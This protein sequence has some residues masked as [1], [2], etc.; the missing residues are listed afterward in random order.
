MKVDLTE[1]EPC[2]KRISIEIPEEKISEEKN[3]AYR[4]LAKSANVPGFRKGRVPRSVLEKMYEERIHSDIAQRLVQSAYQDALSSNNIKPMSDPKV[5]ELKI[6]AGSPITFSATLEVFPE[7]AIEG[8][9]KINL[10][11]KYNKASEEEITSIIDQYRERAARFEPVEERA[12]AE[13]DFAMID[14]RGTHDGEEMEHF[15]GENRQV[16]VSEKEMLSG[17]FEGVNGMKKGEERDFDANL[18][19]DFPD[20]KLKGQKVSF[21]VKLN[22][23]KKKTLPEI[24]DEFAQE[25]SEHDTIEEFKSEIGKM[26]EERSRSMAE[27]DLRTGLIDLI[28]ENNDIELPASQIEKQTEDIFGRKVTEAA[29]QGETKERSEEEDEA[30]KESCRQEAIRSLKEQVILSTF[31]IKEGLDVTPEEVEQEVAAIA[32]MINQSVEATKEQLTQGGRMDGIASKVFSDK[33][34][35]A[36]LS[37]VNIKDQ[38]IEDID[39]K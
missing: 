6:D 2:V 31:G 35:E 16:E 1:I 18:P 15:K 36:M 38:I 14:F 22:E 28:I 19:D 3:S 29:R 7:L 20:E 26:I 25:V 11:R 39:A 34:Y 10:T 27:S 17:F 5:D 12:L 8:L 24:N 9:E 30:L 37:K 13:G 33:V 4:E 21:H 32:G 23:I